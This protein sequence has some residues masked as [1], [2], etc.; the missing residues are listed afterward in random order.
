M[1]QNVRV[2]WRR[3]KGFTVANEVPLLFLE[4]VVVKVIQLLLPI[5][6]S[7]HV[8]LVINDCARGP[9]PRSRPDVIRSFDPRPLVLG[10][11]EFVK[12]ILVVAIIASKDIHA[13]FVNYCRV[14]VSG[15]GRS[16]LSTENDFYF[17]VISKDKDLAFNSMLKFV[18]NPQY[19]DV[20]L[21]F[22]EE[23]S[24]DKKY[25]YAHR[26]LLSKYPYFEKIIDE[27]SGYDATTEETKSLCDEYPDEW[28]G[29]MRPP[30]KLFFPQS[31]YFLLLLL[32]F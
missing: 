28:A 29:R 5:M 23:E 13:V 19:H 8:H 4:I 31:S 18:N 15:S 22:P 6:T 21:E 25:I 10:K 20:V 14:G 12:V 16:F 30:G 11:V 26:L 9:V 32:A 7:K 27:M 17:F 1:S 3:F 24:V 2:P